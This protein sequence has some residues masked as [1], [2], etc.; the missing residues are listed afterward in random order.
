MFVADWASGLFPGMM[1]MLGLGVVAAGRFIARGEKAF[2]IAFVSDT[3]K[4]E[5]RPFVTQA[6]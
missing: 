4:G 5:Q 2:L 3:V 1:M 6:A